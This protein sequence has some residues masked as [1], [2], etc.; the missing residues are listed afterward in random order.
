MKCEITKTAD[1]F[2]DRGLSMTDAITK[3]TFL[4]ICLSFFHG[5]SAL[6][7]EPIE[8]TISGP[9][10]TVKDGSEIP[11]QI[12]ATNKSREAVNLPQS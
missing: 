6:A 1:S 8:I 3:T 11:I 2:F 10:E 12:L 5:G 7:S 4:L 9:T